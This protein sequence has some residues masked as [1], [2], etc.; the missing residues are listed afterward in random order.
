MLT[1]EEVDLANVTASF[2]NSMHSA[3]IN[4]SQEDEEAK[5][6]N[7]EDDESKDVSEDTIML[8]PPLS[9]SHPPSPQEPKREE[10]QSAVTAET[11]R[12]LRVNT[13]VERIIVCSS[14]SSL[15][16]VILTCSICSMCRQEYGRRLA[17][18]LCQVAHRISLPN[19]GN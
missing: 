15:S 9:I 1:D 11:P 19:R 16:C 17:T 5:F 18:C 6:D 2:E 3:D 12:K 13:E 14:G 7:E 8:P 10:V 4:I